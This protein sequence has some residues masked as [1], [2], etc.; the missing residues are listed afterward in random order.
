MPMIDPT[1]WCTVRTA[2]TLA[3]VNRPRVYV[4]VGSGRI[5]SVR[6]DGMI[7]ANR[8]AALAWRAR[9]PRRGRPPLPVAVAVRQADA[10]PSERRRVR[11]TRTTTPTEIVRRRRAS[12]PEPTTTTS[13]T[14]SPAE[15][16]APDNQRRRRPAG[17]A[18]NRRKQAENS[19][20]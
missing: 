17:G 11:T 8:A 13:N 14:T 9:S 12:T 10:M 7:F 18:R 3:G 16:G 1:E 4:L 5:R 20:R 6:I 15:P 19:V 2:A